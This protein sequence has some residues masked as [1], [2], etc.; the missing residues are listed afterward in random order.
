M[1]LSTGIVRINTF[2]TRRNI[3]VPPSVFVDGYFDPRLHV[4][5]LRTRGHLSEDSADLVICRAGK[6]SSHEERRVINSYIGKRIE[7][8]QPLSLG[9]ETRMLPLMKGRARPAIQEL[10]DDRDRFEILLVSEWNELLTEVIERRT[11]HNLEPTEGWNVRTIIQML[12][13]RFNLKLKLDLLPYELLE[14]RVK[15][16]MISGRILRNF[17]ESLGQHFQFYV[18][19]QRQWDGNRITEVSHLRP[20]QNGRP[21]KLNLNADRNCGTVKHISGEVNED[22][23]VKSIGLCGH[24]V[25][26]STLT[27][28]K[29]WNLDLEGLADEQYDKASS[30]DFEQVRNVYRLWI[31]NEDGAFN[32]SPFMQSSY[33]KVEEIFDEPVE[34]DGYTTPFQACLTKDESGSSRGVIVEISMD[35]GATWQHYPGRMRIL[36]ERGGV[37]F[38]DSTLPDTFLSACKSGEAVV[39]V[40]CSLRSPTPI[41]RL[42]AKGNPFMGPF[43]IQLYDLGS[44]FAYQHVNVDSQF[45]NRVIKN[46]IDSDSVDDREALLE[47]LNEVTIR[48]ASMNDSLEV[49]IGGIN[50]GLRIGDRLSSIENVRMGHGLEDTAVRGERYWLNTIEVDYAKQETQLTWKGG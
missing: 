35:S 3:R 5:R 19:H 42:R 15:I 50:S 49:R 30:D 25:A 6:G 37:Y 24:E 18:Q 40:T 17:L 14:R 2:N 34:A 12:N 45:Y 13:S 33:F 32:G 39:R 9:V 7:I 23:P 47:W 28:V 43:R 8:V 1:V 31:L 36:N 27:L 38:D 16:E 41:R 21:I 29:G 48:N 10:G 26:E 20:C 11:L 44:I 46:E 4:R 22:R